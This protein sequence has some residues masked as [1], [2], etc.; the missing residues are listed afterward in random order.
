M[1]N[2]NTKLKPDDAKNI[3]DMVHSMR[4]GT[5]S[6]LA[7]YPVMKPENNP[8]AAAV[9]IMM[10]LENHGRWNHLTVG[11]YI[12]LAAQCRKGSYSNGRYFEHSRNYDDFSYKFALHALASA[13]DAAGNESPL[14]RL[15]CNIDYH[16]YYK[17]ITAKKC[18][19]KLVGFDEPPKLLQVTK[20][21]M[22]FCRAGYYFWKDE[23]GY[24]RNTSDLHMG[25]LY[26]F[27][28][29]PLLSSEN[30]Q[31]KVYLNPNTAI[32]IVLAKPDKGD[33][34]YGKE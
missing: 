1:I 29:E 5:L 34:N 4:L 22:N 33:D 32:D 18:S 12:G 28:I 7:G 26:K 6:V 21:Y 30:E 2:Y 31:A 27:L 9:L 16:Q 3:A 23:N 17:L 25:N 10:D 13:L 24:Y 19:S 20:N 11:E 14:I 15:F 8:L